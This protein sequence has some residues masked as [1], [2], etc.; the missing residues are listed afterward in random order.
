M[1]HR[2]IRVK[3]KPRSAYGEAVEN[4]EKSVDRCGE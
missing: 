1:G 3:L 2:L 4:N